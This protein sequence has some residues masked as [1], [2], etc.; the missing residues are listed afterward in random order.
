LH[1]QVLAGDVGLNGA[2]SLVVE[3]IQALGRGSVAACVAAAPS[4]PPNSF[5]PASLMKLKRPMKNSSVSWFG[6]MPGCTRFV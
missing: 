6:Q 1:A 4:L 3:R 5:S 2:R